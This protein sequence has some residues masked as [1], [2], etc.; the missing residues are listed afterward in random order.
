MTN[1]EIRNKILSDAD[2]LSD[3]I[4]KI[5]TYYQLKHTLRWSHDSAESDEK[6]SV[7]EHVYG[8]YVLSDYFLPL[9]ETPLDPIL[10]RDLILWHDM[11]EALVD[12]MTTLAK[13][14][15]HRELE[16][17]AE[18]HLAHNAPRHLQNK[19][20]EIFSIYNQQEK[21]E[22]QFVKAIDKLEP[23]FQILF[24]CNKITYENNS[25]K[26]QATSNILDKYQADRL[27]YIENFSDIMKFSSVLM[28]MIKQTNYIH[29][30]A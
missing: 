10:V 13:T 25:I 28:E 5:L 16:R 15:S 4:Q 3:E 18:L 29:P 9:Q 8:M 26:L 2:F 7:A 22:A 21:P 11:S 14:D 27:K 30:E 1:A 6:E 20:K 12:D 17:D 23:L 19:L 24:V